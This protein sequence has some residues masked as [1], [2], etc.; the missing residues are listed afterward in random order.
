MS[1]IFISYRRDDSGLWAGRINDALVSRFGA[2]QVFLD[3]DGIRPGEDYRTAIAHTIDE[4]DAV[5]V[6]IGPEWGTVADGKPGIAIEDDAHRF[7]IE[8]A[9]SSEVQLVPV[10]VGGATAPAAEEL[11]T[12]LEDLTDR[13]AAVIDDRSFERDVDALAD[14][15]AEVV[16]PTEAV[17]RKRPPIAIIIGIVIAL[18]VAIGIALSGDDE[19]GSP[20]NTETPAQTI[21][22]S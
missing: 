2:D 10:L 3:V 7:E 12:G 8:S 14:S 19:G 4:A 13:N 20:W 15:L 11:P 22:Q 5:L 6:V 17:T 9:L 1:G 16:T 18:A 21:T